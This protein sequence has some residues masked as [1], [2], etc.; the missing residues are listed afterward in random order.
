MHV[1]EALIEHSAGHIRNAQEALSR[2][3]TL[4]AQGGMIRYFIEQGEPMHEMLVALLNPDSPNQLAPEQQLIARHILVRFPNT[5]TTIP[6]RPISNHALIE[7]EHLTEREL[8]ILQL[9]AT[10]ASNQAI[11]QQ[12]V[13]SLHT[14][15]KHLTHILAKLNAP[16]RTAAVAHARD[17]GML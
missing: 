3:L 6:A 10:G 12:L 14:V 1:L 17:R 2:A 7:T 9:V 13:I 8:E 15:K 4:A 16:S 5:A 11:A